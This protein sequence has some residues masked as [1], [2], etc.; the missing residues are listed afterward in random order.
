MKTLADFKKEIKA[1]KTKDELREISYQA[2]L[3][4]DHAFR[5]KNSLYNKVVTACVLREEELE[6]S[7]VPT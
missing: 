1:A 4:D 5:G 3:Q 7:G 6:K 2:L